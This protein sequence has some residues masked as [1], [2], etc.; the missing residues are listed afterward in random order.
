M[1]SL[2]VS[3]SQPWMRR[4]RRPSGKGSAPAALSSFS[5]TSTSISFSHRWLRSF[6]LF[7][8]FVGFCTFG[9]FSSVNRPGCLDENRERV[10]S[11]T[12]T[13]TRHP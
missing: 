13:L 6:S 12:W 4:P 3:I 11:L 2:R 8:F 5:S 9:L 10:V 7:R 1:E